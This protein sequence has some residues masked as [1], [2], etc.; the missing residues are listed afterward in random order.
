[1]NFQFILTLIYLNKMIIKKILYSFLC[2]YRKAKRK[3]KQNRKLSSMISNDC[4]SRKF[5]SSV[6]CII[7]IIVMI[8]FSFFTS[9]VNKNPICR[10]YIY[11]NNPKHHNVALISHKIGTR[12]HTTENRWYC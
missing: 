7:I 3:R 1:M 11:E 9:G 5:S 4:N 10:L 12:T 8:C 2:E 6:R